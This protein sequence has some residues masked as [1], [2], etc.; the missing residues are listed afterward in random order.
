MN[1]PQGFEIGPRQYLEHF[2]SLV[3]KLRGG[4][5]R[6]LPL[7][8]NKINESLPSGVPRGLPTSAMVGGSST[9]L[10]AL[11]FP[12]DPAAMGPPGLKSEYSDMSASIS[13]EMDEDTYETSFVEGEDSAMGSP[14]TMQHHSSYPS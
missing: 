1:P 13:D 4:R 5:E 14:Y 11:D 7:L 9:N 10:D 12:H 2:L 8:L 3:A 6:Y